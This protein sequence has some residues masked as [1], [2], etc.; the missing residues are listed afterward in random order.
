MVEIAPY[1]TWTS[2]LSAADVA[3]SGVSAQWL[4]TVGD[5]VWWAEPRTG[6]GGRVTLVRARA[7]GPI[8]DVLPAPWNA[9]NRV[10]E[11]GGRP[12]LVDGGVL[13][14]THWA[15]QRVHRRDLTTGETTPLT[16]EPASRHGIRYSDLRPGRPGEVWLVRERSTGPRRVDIARD[17]VALP[18]DGGPERVLSASHHF[19]TAPQL[20]PDGARAAWIGWNHP[21]MPWDGTELCVADVGEDGTFGPH[22]VLAGAADVAVC[23][24]EWESA[25]SLLA[26]LDP[27][28]W[29]NLH[30]VGLD[31]GLENLAPAEQEIGGAMW[32][33]GARWFT[34]LGDGRFAVI[35][36]GKLAVLD[37]AT[38]E[39]TPVAAAADLTAWST[40]G[41]AVHDGGVVGVAAGPDREAA[42]VKVDLR[43]G[44]VTELAS[45]PEPPSPDYL[46]RPVERIFKTGDGDR[47]PA[48]V[49]LPANAD[50]AAP[51]GERPPLLVYPHGGPTGRDSAVLDFEIAYFTSRGIAVVTVNYGGSTGYGRAY[52]ERLRAQWGVVD[53]ADCVAV[54]EALAAEGTVDGDRL[55]IRGGSAGGYTSAASL[56]TTTTYRAGTVMYPILDL[57]Q[58]TG[59]G[60][61]THDFESRYLDGLI[62]PLP[63]T[64]QR[65][66]ERSPIHNA[67]TVAGPLL[68]LQGVEDEIC[69]PE[70]ADRFVAGLAGRGI[71]HAYLR[72]EGEQ[73]GFRK[74]ETIVAA[75]EAELSFYGQVFGFETP[76][77]PK[78]RLSR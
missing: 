49:Y 76:G 50:F 45:A 59:D 47:V 67:G 26:L 34:P 68:F 52:R 60:G 10:H 46:S 33:L 66:R 44:T 22:R 53:V 3:A 19:L 64:E 21:A 6:D 1:G 4:A 63:E 69:P 55:A 12:W 9:R 7:D 29:W 43:D 51:D 56:T 28:G 11:Y 15:D 78:L 72:F 40:N 42:V 54:A 58:W 23:Q 36:S 41:F 65:Y 25:D 32:K 70:Q 20:S 57:Y 77:V 75:L 61:E 8:E 39:V 37:E 30:R 62:G 24:V 18:L 5:E 71:D 14:F 31:G 2:P 35:A 13:V 74:A 27:D 38:R 48:F 16:P 73:H 17:L